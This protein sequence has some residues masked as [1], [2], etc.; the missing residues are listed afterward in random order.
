[1]IIHV[2]IIIISDQFDYKDV[3][4]NTLVKCDYCKSLPVRCWRH[5]LDTVTI[6]NEGVE[7]S[8]ASSKVDAELLEF[9]KSATK[10]KNVK[11]IYQL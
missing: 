3:D 9:F 8:P 2:L 6:N 11:I 1:M 7:K 4:V 5:C 10:S